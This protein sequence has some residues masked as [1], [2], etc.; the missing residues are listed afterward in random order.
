MEKRKIYFRVRGEY[1]E[2]YISVDN[3]ALDISYAI[4][5]MDADKRLDNN[6]TRIHRMIGESVTEWM[7][8]S[9]AIYDTL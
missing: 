2:K 4:K 3:N 1:D 8:F 9:G 6:F 5:I 7:D